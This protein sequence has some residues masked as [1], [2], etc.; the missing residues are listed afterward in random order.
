MTKEFAYGVYPKV[1][2]QTPD[3]LMVR[4]KIKN[5]PVFLTQGSSRQR[6]KMGHLKGSNNVFTVN[7]WK[8]LYLFSWTLLF[9][10]NRTVFFNFYFSE[11]Q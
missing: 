2:C 10:Y 4:V 9:S 6:Q 5:Y 11:S 1:L 7:S 3:L 8:G